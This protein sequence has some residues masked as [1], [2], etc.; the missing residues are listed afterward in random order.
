[1]INKIKTLEKIAHQLE[2]SPEQRESMRQEVIQ[3]TEKFLNDIYTLNAYNT[4]KDIAKGLLENPISD[5]PAKINDLTKSLSEYVDF[6]GLN[7][8]SHGHLGYVPGGGIYYSALGDYI[9]AITNRYAG[10]SFASPGAVTME[11]M[12]IDWMADIVGYPKTTGGNLTS[13]GSIANMIGIVTA[14]EAHDLRAKDFHKTVIYYTDQ[15]HHSSVKDIGVAGLKECIQ[16][17]VPMDDGHRMDA[18]AL[19]KL[20]VED[21]KKG[22]NPWL[23][24]ASAGTTNLGAVDPLKEI[25][26]IAKHHNMWFHVDGAYG[27]FFVLT[28]EG[29]TKL[30]GMSDSDS[31]VMDPHKGLFLP[32]G[33]G[34]VL[35]RDKKKLYNA[36]HYEAGYL[37][38]ADIDQTMSPADASP[39]L[40]KHFRG[41]R[42]W[43]PL[44]LHGLKP[45][46]AALEEKLLLAK[47]F[48]EKVQEIDGIEVGPYP[49]LSIATFRYVPKKGDPNE[50]NRRLLD[51][52][53]E[54]GRVFM[55]STTI[56]EKFVI[57]MAALSF[58][59][60]LNTIDLAL[61]IIV[62]KIKEL[63]N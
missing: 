52:I 42:L 33:S 24:I 58:R 30:K 6:P 17:L 31:L 57:R 34:V 4:P 18:N 3:Y 5:E 49:D 60:H 22:L 28:Q 55:S 53:Y 56:N 50:F 14:R 26:S 43:L 19:E 11:N 45:F 51:K 61:D 25:N 10:I 37:Q 59:A 23:I 47:Y 38:D 13:G 15:M 16:K 27:G 1:M 12:L 54:D 8:A 46:K 48:Y 39:E 40:T 9:A 21:K 2:P 44:K 35:V 41:L 20:I 63:E 29:K 36:H 7:T 62:K 32:F